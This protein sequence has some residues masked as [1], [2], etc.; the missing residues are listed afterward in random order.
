MGKV[1]TGWSR[2]MS[3]QIRRQ[4]DTVVSP[5]SKLTKPIRKPKATWVEPSFMAEVEFRDITSEGLLR[6]SSF[7]GLSKGTRRPWQRLLSMSE[8]LDILM[9]DSIQIAWDYLKRAGE[10]DD[11]GMA[12]RFLVIYIEGLIRRGERRRLLL[13]NKAITAYQNSKQVREAA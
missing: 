12:R 2:T 9:D 4:L 13:S 11:S 1:G 5:K 3:S 7:K 8:P 10:I 6:Q